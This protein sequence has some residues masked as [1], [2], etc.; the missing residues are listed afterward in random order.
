MDTAERK[1]DIEGDDPRWMT[2]RRGD[3]GVR[4]EP[5]RRA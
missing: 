3:L 5:N 1:F 4:R 2:I